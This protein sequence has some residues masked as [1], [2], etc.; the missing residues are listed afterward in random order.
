MWLAF[1]QAIC[2]RYYVVVIGAVVA[3]IDTLAWFEKLT[4]DEMLK[5]ICAVLAFSRT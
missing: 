5:A 4:T 3:L 1:V 2:D